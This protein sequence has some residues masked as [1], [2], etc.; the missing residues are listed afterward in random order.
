MKVN[1]A[2]KVAESGIGT[3]AVLQLAAAIP[4]LD[5]GVSLTSLYLAEDIVRTPLSFAGGHATVPPGAGLG[6]EVDEAR[7]RRYQRKF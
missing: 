1:L 6:I 3:A 5:W 4:S 2:C 7:V